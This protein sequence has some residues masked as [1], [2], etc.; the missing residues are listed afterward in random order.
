MKEA[1]SRI[2]INELLTKSGWNFDANIKL[3]QSV[4]S[5]DGSN[6]FADYL[7]LDSKGHPLCII[8]AKRPDKSPLEGKE[9]A[10]NYARELRARFIIL[11]NGESHYFWDMENGNPKPIIEYPTQKTLEEAQTI[12]LHPEKLASITV[13]ENY[14]AETQMPGFT[15]TPEYKSGGDIKDKFVSDHNL[16]ILRS[17]QLGAIHAVQNAAKTGKERYLLE[18][19]TG[20]GKTKTTIALAKLFLSTSN[21]H[22]ILFLV[23]RIEL[24]E[25]AAKDFK[26]VLKDWVTVIYKENKNDWRKANIVITTVQ[27]LMH[28]DRYKK[29]FSPTDFDLVV[30]DEAHRSISGNARA[31]F[32]YFIGYKLGLTATPKDYLKNLEGKEESKKAIERR[33]LLD[34]YKTFGCESGE[35]TYRYD[36]QTGAKDGFLIQPYVLDAR[37]QITTELLSKEGFEVERVAEDGATEKQIYYSRHFERKFFND[38]TNWEFCKQ[39]IEKGEHDPITDEYGKTLVFCRTQKHAT[40]IT[41]IL[42]E[43]AMKKWPSVYNSDFAVQI[44]SNVD[45]A[46]QMTTNFTNNKLN[47]TSRFAESNYPEYKTSKTR[48]CITVSMMTTGYDC[49]DLLNIAFMRP[50]F[51][52]ADFIQMKGRGTRKHNFVYKPDEIKIE[53]KSFKLFDFFAV[54]EFFENDFKYNEALKLPA[55]IG[56]FNPADPEPSDVYG[57]DSE[58]IKA[59]SGEYDHAS[60]DQ[61]ASVAEK[62]IDHVGMRIDREAFGP[63]MR[64]ELSKDKTLEDLYRSGDESGAE[65]Y[66]KRE[67]YDRPSLYV[68]RD[69]VKKGFNLDRLP[70]FSEI[71]EY[72][73]GDREG[74]DTNKDILQRSW[75]DFISI[76]GDMVNDNNIDHAFQ[77]FTAYAQND[78]VRK[79]IDSRKYGNLDQYGLNDDWYNLDDSLRIKIPAYTK[80]FVLDK[81]RN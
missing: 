7:L 77:V 50:V 74:F 36:L 30:S 1:D 56:T 35:P 53:K 51:S 73:F 63:R 27:S 34:T 64:E 59:L 26:D 79:I 6:T 58:P 75:D 38:A 12:N 61:I 42:N 22:R 4:K 66:F 68:T 80:D 49:P 25:Q 52:P 76:H 17:Y 62:Q 14:L 9:Q 71:L 21:A 3:E 72:I 11:S 43:I 65:E 37:T 5:T 32:E 8:E 29:E 15:Q 81:V 55:T 48:I 20:T 10:R 41:Q 44:T 54:C 24:E 33:E 69:R 23:D 46:Q 60:P 57:D 19:A 40:K 47:G 28:N 45:E 70:T 78:E 67:I 31:V 16:I 39:L 18:M 2:I 13:D